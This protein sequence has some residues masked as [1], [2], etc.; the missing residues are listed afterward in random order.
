MLSILKKMVKLI[1]IQYFLNLTKYTSYINLLSVLPFFL[2]WIA[3]FIIYKVSPNIKLNNTYTLFSSLVATL[4]FYL[5]KVLFIYYTL[6]NTT[7]KSIYG[8][9]SLILFLFLWIY[10]SWIIFFIGLY[11]NKFLHITYKKS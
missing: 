7:Y 9:F 2:I 6:I 10:V 8:P 1:K 5:A 4:I 3:F 11:L